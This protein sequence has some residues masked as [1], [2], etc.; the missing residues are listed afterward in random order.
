MSNKLINFFNLIKQ[1]DKFWKRANLYYERNEKRTTWIGFIFS[2]LYAFLYFSFFIYKLIR[3]MKKVD[4]SVYDTFA[5]IEKP[6]SINITNNNFYVGFGLETEEYDPFIDETIYYPK[7]FFKEGIRNGNEWVWDIKN[8]ELEKCRIE[9][10]GE[11]F[12]EKFKTNAIGNLYCLK[13]VNKT[14]YGHF[15][16]DTYSFF[17]IQLFPCKN[18]TENNNHCKPKEIID[19]YLNGNYFCMEFEDVE[20]TPQNYSNPVRPRNQDIYFTVSKKLFQEVHI[21]FQIINVETDK[22]I[23]GLQLEQFIN[24]REDEYLKY[25]SAYYMNNYIEND[26]YETDEP[27]CDITIKLHDQIRIQRRTYPKLINIWG[28]IGGFMEFIFIIFNLISFFPI[29]ILYE[30]EIVNKLFKFDIENKYIYVKKFQKS[31]IPIDFQEIYRINGIQDENNTS[32]YDEIKI[33]EINTENSSFNDDKI[34]KKIIESHKQNDNIKLN[35]NNKLIKCL[36]LYESKIKENN[37]KIIDNIRIN[38][39]FIYL[40]CFCSR[41]FKNKNNF[42]LD[43]GMEIFIDKMNIFTIF[44]KSINNEMI[45]NKESIIEIFDLPIKL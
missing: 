4:V 21:F 13:E 7:A 18:N 15:S 25:H 38:P 14:L 24:M 19:K 43:K 5:H 37:I 44:K 35:S 30:T 27:F 22:D 45:L 2:I 12:R 40:F 1:F 11:S 23:F 41:K 3:M 20:L 26:I 29:D 9:N 28:D 10:F 16:Y 31:K 42:L 17:Y 32:K 33:K 34:Q 8:V 39:I 36:E 6:P